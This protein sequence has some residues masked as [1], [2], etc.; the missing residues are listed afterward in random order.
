MTPDLAIGHAFGALLLDM[1]KAMAAVAVAI[2]FIFIAGVMDGYWHERRARRWTD[3]GSYRDRKN[4]WE[5]ERSKDDPWRRGN[6][7]DY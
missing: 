5:R 7:S 2:A 3:P 1:A 4:L 6:G